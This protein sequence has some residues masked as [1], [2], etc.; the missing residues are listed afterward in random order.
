MVYKV[1]AGLDQNAYYGYKSDHTL[2]EKEESALNVTNKHQN[3]YKNRIL[4]N[5]EAFDASEV[6]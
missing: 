4:L 3:L 2:S 1:V 5:W 6:I